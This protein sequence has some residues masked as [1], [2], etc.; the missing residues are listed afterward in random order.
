MCCTE[1][2]LLNCVVPEAWQTVHWVF[3]LMVPVCQ[4][5]V[6]CPPWQLTFPQLSSAELSNVAAPVLAL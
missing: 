6:A 5:G 4:F 2:K 1:L 3:T